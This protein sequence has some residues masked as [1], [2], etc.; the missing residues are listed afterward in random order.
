MNRLFRGAW[1]GNPSFS[2]EPL[3]RW[4]GQLYNHYEGLF[5]A[6]NTGYT[7]FM[8]P[9]PVNPNGGYGLHRAF[10]VTFGSNAPGEAE[11]LKSTLAHEMFHTFQPQMWKPSAADGSLD[12]AWFDEGLAVFYQNALPYRY[13]MMSDEE[14]LRGVNQSAAVYYA[15]PFIDLPNA[16]IPGRFWSDT[17]VRLIPYERGF[18]YFSIVDAALRKVSGGRSSLD[19]IVLEL[20]RA[21]NNGQELTPT[22]WSDALRAPLGEP[23]QTAFQ[24]MLAGH[25][26]VPDSDVF[27]PC[28]QRV[29]KFAR[30]Y[31]LGFDPKVLTEQPR[32]VRGILPDSEAARSG[33]RN[34]DEI[35]DPV[36]QDAI[37]MDQTATL[38]LNIMRGAAR[39]PITYLPRG[40]RVSVWQW[41]RKAS[42]RSGEDCRLPG[43]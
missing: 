8:R 35:V 14:F 19:D 28:F 4:A 33:L 31:E 21:Q 5:S 10:I 34:G 18:V 23:G 7:V 43:R 24:E 32:I 27:G 2:A 9:N 29:R 15:N 3:L 6:E 30:R 40:E 20:R 11:F 25:E 26:M 36:S 1:V 12:V 22:V 17:R 39:I 38:K 42:A 16:D 41:E 37:Q 13:G